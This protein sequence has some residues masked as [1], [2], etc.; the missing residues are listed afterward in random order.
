MCF[1]PKTYPITSSIIYLSSQ[2]VVTPIIVL[3]TIIF[4]K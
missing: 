1:T 2:G 3:N 4:S